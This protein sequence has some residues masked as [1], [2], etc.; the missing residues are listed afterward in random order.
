MKRTYPLKKLTLALMA[1]AIIPTVNAQNTNTTEDSS[2]KT[3]NHISIKMKIDKDG[4]ITEVDTSF[5]IDYNTIGNAEEIKAKLKEMGLAPENLSFDME[6]DFDFS[7]LGENVYMFKAGDSTMNFEDMD[8]SFVQDMD[9]EAMN[10][11]FLGVM[12]GKTVVDGDEVNTIEKGIRVTDVIEN[13][14]AK[15][16]GVEK[17][18]I[19]LSVDGNETNEM[20]DLTNYL[21]EKEI[22][23]VVTLSI[24]RNGE[25]ISK[26]VTLGKRVMA[27]KSFNSHGPMKM[28]MDVKDFGEASWE[29]ADGENIT[30]KEIITINDNGDTIKTR[31]ISSNKDIKILIANEGSNVSIEEKDVEGVY[32]FHFAIRSIDDKSFEDLDKDI[33]KKVS[34]DNSLEVDGLNIYPNPNNGVFNLK[35]NLAEEGKVIVRIFD[36]NGKEVY[37]D[38]ERKFKGEY[39]KEI[40]LTEFGN[41]TYIINIEQNDKSTVKKIIVN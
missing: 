23:D 3:E 24:N 39:N 36:V 12:L 21:A 14:G 37:T 6:M 9:S 26:D 11:P 8:F 19:I 27:F 33:Q 30:I 7:E 22:G 41:G 5:T 25:E 16:A 20:E 35:F 2:T 40:D 38:K 4:E 17:G 15:E 10:R 34:P 13:T 29:D 18:D 31:E 1:L 32:T 28:M